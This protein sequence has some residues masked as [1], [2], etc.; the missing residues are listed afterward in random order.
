[1]VSKSTIGLAPCSVR[2]REAVIVQQD[3]YDNVGATVPE[4]EE[5][6]EWPIHVSHDQIHNT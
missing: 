5:N 3:Q 1:M 2:E 6:D 4:Q